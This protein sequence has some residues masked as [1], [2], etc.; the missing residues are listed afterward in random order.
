MPGLND[1]TN[2]WKNIREVDLRP[3]RA[4]ATRSIHLALVGAT[5]SGRNALAEQLHND[6]ARPTMR[7]VTPLVIAEP[8]DE[9]QLAGADLIVLLV[10]ANQADSQRERDLADR[11]TRAGQKVIVLI[12]QRLGPPAPSAERQDGT[13]ARS[14]LQTGWNA[15]RLIIGPAEQPDFL[16]KEFAPAV[17]H[18]LPDQLLSLGRHFPLF[19]V[20]I[21]N[22][23][24]NDTSLSNAA[25]AFS[26]G[27]AEI[28]PLLD[29]PLNVT[30]MLILTK[31][32]AFLAYRLG[33]ALGY[34]T[35]WQD[36]V[37][38]FGSVIGGG[39]VWRQ[40]AR[41]LIGLIPVWGIVPKVAVAYAGTYV[42]GQAI[43]RWYLTGRHVTP[44][45]LR[46][47]YRQ[48]FVQ[49]KTIARDLIARAP[50]PRSG[51]RQALP[52]ASPEPSKPARFRL[53]WR[54]KTPRRLPAPLA[55]RTCPAC[56]K[57]SAADAR[58]CQ[59]CGTPLEVR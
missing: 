59:Y 42:V 11:L 10:D 46:A 32:Q 34:S 55:V 20:P 47:L 30:D 31:A 17:M 9:E 54:R 27:L 50:K 39:F 7:T 52:A 29:I 12:N 14:S 2:F 22:R 25:Y 41:T 37:A 48:A 35:N 18:L 16:Q 15:P 58:F 51:V 49:G 45:Q 8:G 36:Y 53:P 40:L 19:R 5:G 26:T 28:V 13:A 21:A 43:L 23:L 1:L 44:E 3:I 38:E 33:L 56:G 4:E 57:S 24:I 6:P